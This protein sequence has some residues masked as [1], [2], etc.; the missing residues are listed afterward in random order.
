MSNYFSQF[1]GLW[2]DQRD[3]LAVAQGLAALANP[4]DRQRVEHFIR[5]GYVVIENAVPHAVIDA[6]LAEYD[7]A[8]QTGELMME[9]PFHGRRT[10]DATV[11]AKPGVKVLD[12]GMVLPSGHDL[13]FAPAVAQFL[14]LL[15]KEP[16]LA[17]QTLHFEM[18]STQAI[19]QDTAYVVVDKSPLH[20][21]ATWLALEDIASGSGEL[22]YYAGGHRLP[23][24]VYADGRKHW[25]HE[26]DGNPPHDAHLAN[27][28]QWA[29][30]RGLPMQQFLPKKGDVLFWHADLPH[31]GNQITV[32]G[33][34]RKSLVTHYCPVSLRPYYSNFIAENRRHVTPSVNGNGYMSLYYQPERLIGGI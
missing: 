24:T 19:H 26:K 5:Y 10:Y 22:V 30:E 4:I 31:G 27:L 12:T 18:G 11:R 3:Q 14:K 17:F 8:S 7:R 13:C 21:V 6:Y 25:N 20:L 15:F 34:T 32:P 9:V 28:R 29:Q 16:A 23:E 2:V 33:R 1:G